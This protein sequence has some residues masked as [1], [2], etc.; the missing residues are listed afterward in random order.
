[1]RSSSLIYIA[2]CAALICGLPG[3]ARAAEVTCDGV[4]DCNTLEGD[5]DIRV[6]L[7]KTCTLLNPNT[8]G[9]L[10]VEADSTVTVVEKL[11]NAANS[12]LGSVRGEGAASVVLHDTTVSGSVELEDCMQLLLLNS[13]VDGEIVLKCRTIKDGIGTFLAHNS[14]VNRKVYAQECRGRFRV[15]DQSAL[16]QGLEVKGGE[17]IVEIDESNMGDAENDGCIIFKDRTGDITVS[18]SSIHGK[19]EVRQVHGT[20]RLGDIDALMMGALVDGGSGDMFFTNVVSGISG[21]TDGYLEFKAR[22]GQI[23][24]ESGRCGT[25]L[26]PHSPQNL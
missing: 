2:A 12:K 14:E 21:G 11:A 15:E 25:E 18:K 17:G 10:V 5:Y 1:M 16:L 22:N 19:L 9:K 24:I 3:I 4:L 23:V 13:R 20:V 8:P 7:S 26:P 6:Q